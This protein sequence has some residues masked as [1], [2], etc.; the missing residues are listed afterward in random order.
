M[1]EI[2][3]ERKLFELP[4][5]GGLFSESAIH[6]SNLPISKEKIFQKTILNLKF[7]IPAHSIILLW[8]GILNFKFRIVFWNI[9]SLEIWRFE[10][11]IALSE[12]KPPLV[13]LHICKTFLPKARLNQ[14]HVMSI[15]TIIN[16]QFGFYWYKLTKVLSPATK[17]SF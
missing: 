6:F 16:L 15:R 7:K 11:C 1:K 5:K 12:N 14:V 13:K 9:F 10:K 4:A 2:K 17:M 8:A 3:I